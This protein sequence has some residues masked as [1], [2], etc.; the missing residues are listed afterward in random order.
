MQRTD[1][2]EKTLM[3]RKIGGRRK[4][5]DRGWDGWMASL[6]QWTWVWV[7]SGSWWWTGR[8][9]VLQ[10]MGSQRVGHYWVTELN[11]TT[12]NEIGIM[13]ESP[14]R[15]VVGLDEVMFVKDLVPYLAHSKC[16]VNNVNIIN[17]GWVKRWGSEFF[18]QSSFPKGLNWS[19]LSLG[20]DPWRELWGSQTLRE[21]LGP[22]LCNKEHHSYTSSVC[23]RGRVTLASNTISIVRNLLSLWMSLFCS[24]GTVMIRIFVKEYL[25]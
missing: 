18:T 17:I 11:W 19:F 10:S 2:L 21:R 12:N 9:G 3:L 5:D 24:A 1:S 8:P 4:G 25:L 23:H 7:N 22:R 20:L 15:V 6:T 14:C 16:S 13:I